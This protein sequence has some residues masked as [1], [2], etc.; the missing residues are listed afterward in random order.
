[1]TTPP[2]WFALLLRL[3]PEPFRSEY[4]ADI[5]EHATNVLGGGSGLRRAAAWLRITVDVVLV[6]MSLRLRGRR[7]RHHEL[8]GEGR[9]GPLLDTLRQDVRYGIRSVRRDPGFAVFATLIV[10]LGVGASVTVFSVAQALLV[11]P[12]PFSDPDRLVWVANG[13]WGRGQQLSEI[14]VQSDYVRDLR[15]QSTQFEDVAGYHLFDR[16]GD[17]TLSRADGSQRLTRLRVTEHFFSVL[18]VGPVH[19]RLFTAEEAWDDGPPAI[20]LTHGFWQRVFASDVD[21]VGSALNIDGRPTT[22]VGVLPE[23]FDFSTI[24]APGRRIDYVAPFPLSARSNRSGNTLGVIGRLSPGATLASASAEARAIAAR[25]DV[26]IGPDGRRRNGF[27]PVLSPLR[28]HVSGSF[29]ASVYVLLGAVGLVMLIV[30]AN[31]SNLLLA[32]STR[33]QHEMAIRTTLGAARPRLIRQLLTEA[34]L[35]SAV[36]AGLGIVLAYAGTSLISGLDLRIPLLAETRVD[37]P[38]LV[39]AVLLSAGAGLLFGVVPA[40]RS[41]SVRLN[42]ALK[43]NARGS[44]AGRR[45]GRLRGL[46]V[47]SEVALACVLLVG[48]VLMLRS[49]ERLLD[50][51]PGYEAQNVVALRIDP[52]ARFGTND[53]R[54]AFYSEA[55]RRVRS[56]PGV[57]AAGLSDVLPMGFNRR[58]DVRRSDA[59]SEDESVYP[60]VRVASD[61]YVDALRLVLIGGRDLRAEDDASTVPVALVNEALAE[62][63]WSESDPVGS[64]IVSGGTDF[65]VVGIVRN[66]RQL[67][68]EQDPGPEIFFSARQLDDQ[69]AVHLIVRGE[70]SSSGLIETARGELRALDASLPLDEVTSIRAILDAS[71]APRRFLV[72]LIAGF[73]LFALCLASLGIYG[74]IS[75]S[76]AL[77]RREIGIHMALGAPIRGLRTSIVRETLSVAAVG[78]AAGLVGAALTSRV[79]E[80]MLYGVTPLDPVTYLSA[81]ALLSGVAALAGYVPARRATR[82][83]PLSALSGPDQSSA[84]S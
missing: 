30:C 28:E 49:L 75:C 59:A 51:D 82:L 35:L 23:R 62:L 42:D 56:A 41:T 78:L 77:R 9:S 44:T 48:S 79:L 66:T 17:R 13:E 38:A 32:R 80:S 14:S 4:A 84:S 68:L 18:D 50:V 15:G 19:G 7:A 67:S 71:I 76:V 45:G 27:E 21:V 46:L 5:M 29:R 40:V 20:L 2:G 31:L 8:A 22:V 33:R 12:L 10:G 73:A 74:V 83:N 52:S 3:L 16:D 37:G 11:R 64:R 24:F 36:G 47:M 6:A 39:A 70:G 72:V 69:N 54:V 1:M 26:T 34:L 60:F 57:A 53:E 61:G 81:I 65:T 58:W 25:G 55:L 43:D 63:L